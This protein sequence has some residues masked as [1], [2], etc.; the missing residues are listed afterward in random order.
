MG[1]NRPIYVMLPLGSE[2]EWQLYKSCASQ[3]GLKGAEVVAEIATLPVGEINVH[4]TGVMIE[5][6]ISDPIAVEQLSE[7]EWQGFTHRVILGSEL[8][9][10]NSEALNLVVVTDEFDDDTFTQNIDTE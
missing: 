7:D 4:N 8:M 1:G 10:I 5:E 6:T 2:D 9:K 3:S